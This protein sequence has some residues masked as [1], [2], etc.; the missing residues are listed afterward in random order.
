LI[1]LTKEYK[2]LEAM[3]TREKP[4]SRDPKFDN[5]IRMPNSKD[6]HSVENSS[7][8]SSPLMKERIMPAGTNKSEKQMHQ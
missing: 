4:I 3:N 2:S 7:R 6:S 1:E 8:Q 5:Q